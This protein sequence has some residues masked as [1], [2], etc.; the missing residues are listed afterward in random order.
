MAAEYYRPDR[1]SNDAPH[2]FDLQALGGNL[3]RCTGYRPIRDAAYALGS[4]DPADPLA[5]RQDRPAPPARSTHLV[6]GTGEFW[7]VDAQCLADVL[8]GCAAVRLR[9]APTP[10]DVLRELPPG[11]HVV[12]MTHDHAEDLAL[13]D[14]ALRRGDLG[15]VG[16]IG[17]TAKWAR[18][19]SRLRD[20][21]HADAEIDRISCPIGQPT[22]VGKE[23][24]VIA[25]GVAAALLVTLR[26]SGDRPRTGSAEP[27]EHPGTDRDDP[28]VEH[29][30]VLPAHRHGGTPQ[31]AA[32]GDG[33]RRDARRPAR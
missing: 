33:D 31:Q 15:T 7:Q 3:C 19:R 27:D 28:P 22:I 10:V 25:I 4:P 9:H 12:V 32:V 1:A 23:P 26:P 14:A 24:A 16:L 11:A 5:R 29:L 6:T 8:G 17:S 2:G 13:C 20:A 21:G 18:S 30:E